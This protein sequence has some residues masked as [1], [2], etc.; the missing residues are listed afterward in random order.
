MYPEAL[1]GDNVNYICT[2]DNG[3]LGKASSTTSSQVSDLARGSCPSDR[4]KR[5]T[6]L[7]TI[8]GQLASGD[9]AISGH[10]VQ[11]FNYSFVWQTRV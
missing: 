2:R 8:R 11:S 10:N 3:D 5:R 1:V 6:V 4:F 7:M 9:E